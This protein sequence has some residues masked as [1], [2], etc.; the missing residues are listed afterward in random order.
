VGRG[1]RRAV[2][3]TQRLCDAIALEIAGALTLLRA[4]TL[5]TVVLEMPTQRAARSRFT[6]VVA[7]LAQMRSA[8]CAIQRGGRD[9]RT[10]GEGI[11][12]RQNAATTHSD[13][14]EMK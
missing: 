4:I 10:R 8:F 11:G 5:C 2:R 9:R 13:A 7:H 14:I 12:P 6:L 3:A 1:L